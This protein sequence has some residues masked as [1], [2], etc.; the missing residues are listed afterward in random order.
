MRLNFPCLPLVF[1]GKVGSADYSSGI[2]AQSARRGAPQ[3][4]GDVWRR[5]Y[6]RRTIG[7]EGD[8][9]NGRAASGRI[10]SLLYSA[11]KDELIPTPQ[12][13]LSHSICIAP[14]FQDAVESAWPPFCAKSA[15]ESAS[16]STSIRAIEAIRPRRLAS[17]SLPHETS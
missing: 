8:R 7:A 12:V 2:A 4:D 5:L 16:V 1:Q 6:G 14:C 9:V 10:K 13:S 3:R 11:G 17:L 15:A